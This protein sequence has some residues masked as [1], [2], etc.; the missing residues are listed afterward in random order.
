MS[1]PRVLTGLRAGLLALVLLLLVLPVLGGAP[2]RAA[3]RVAD[4]AD[5]SAA[6]GAATPLTVQLTR[7]EPAAIPKHGT[8]VLTGD[9]TNSSTEQWSTV[10]VYPFLSH[11][12][13]TTRDELAAAAKSDPAAEVG[14]RIVKPGEFASIGNLKPGQT[15]PFQVTVKV[16]DLGITGAQGVYWIGVHALGQDAEGR[17]RVAD[18]RARTFIP[19]VHSGTPQTSIAVVVPVRQKVRR[20]A[21]GRL[22][23]TDAWASSL[24]STG[25]LGRLAGFIASAGTRAETLLVDP[26]VLDA[27]SDLSKDNPAISLG[28]G[29]AVTPSPS[30]S[31]SPSSSGSG[32]DSDS[33]SRD[34]DRI[35]PGDRAAALTWL[36]SVVSAAKVHSVL[37]LGYADPDVASLARHRPKLIALSNK[38]A[39]QTFTSLK[40]PAVPTVAPPDGWFDDDLLPKVPAESMVLVSD[41]SAPRSRTQWRTSDHQDLVFTDQQAASGGPGP[42]APL[43]ALALRQRILSDAAL[44]IGEHSTTPLVV[45]LPDDWDPGPNWPLSDF[46][47]SLDQPWVTLVPITPGSDGSTPTFDAALGYPTSVRRAEVSNDS[48]SVARNLL[49]TASIFNGLLRSTNDVAH[50]LGGIAFDAVSENARHDQVSTRADVDAT[51]TR[52]RA[53]LGKVQVTGTDFVT[54][55]GGTGTL[56]V[57]LVNGLDQ[58]VTVGLRASASTDDV[59]IAPVT[60]L[61]MEPGQRTVIRLKANASKVGVTQVVLSPV[62][63]GGTP[64]G[65]PLTFRLRTS[66]VG[67]LIWIVLLA[68]AALLVVMIAR[69]IARRLRGHSWRDA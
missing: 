63:A 47:G 52:M 3:T 27:V 48:V 62:T 22:L 59:R 25:R 4:V 49:A 30:P 42:T 43:D 69:R 56:A 67:D 65:T 11:S 57:T 64:L 21:D 6:A 41:H 10:R 60:P 28:D 19:L 38:L 53:E 58:P 50:D 46:F 12:P 24:A 23:D 68:G 29:K 39:A 31:P 7:L 20:D 2:A 9:V 35:E 1:L 14:N 40:I 17:D 33:P 54:L 18:G 26:A 34:G 13:M 5:K 61:K 55:S 37:G 45:E 36:D 44:R 66:Q 16:K 8:I 51:N 32:S 15:T